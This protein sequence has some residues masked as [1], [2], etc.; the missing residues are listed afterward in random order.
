MITVTLLHVAEHC[1]LNAINALDLEV[2]EERMSLPHDILNSGECNPTVPKTW[3][4]RAKPE[5][6]QGFERMQAVKEVKQ[7]KGMKHEM[8]GDRRRRSDASTSCC[9]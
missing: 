2:N 7:E 8:G 9:D 1:C 6:L 4:L 3:L 5:E